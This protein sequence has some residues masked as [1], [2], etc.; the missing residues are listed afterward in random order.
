MICL[1]KRSKCGKMPRLVK[2]E[3]WVLVHV[4]CVIILSVKMYHKRRN[5]ELP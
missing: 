5:E 4:Y 3:Q 2:A 1:H